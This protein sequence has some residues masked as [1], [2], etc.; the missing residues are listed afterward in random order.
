VPDLLRQALQALQQAQETAKETHN[1][2][3]L[4]RQ[5]TSQIRSSLDL[6]TI[7]QGAVTTIHELLQVESCHFI[8]YHPHAAASGWE[9]LQEARLPHVPSLGWHS[10]AYVES[11]AEVFLKQKLLRVNDV[12]ILDQP[13]LQTV[14]RNLGIKSQLVLPIRTHSGVVGALHC[15]NFSELYVWSDED[16]EWLQDILEQLAIAIQQAELTAEL[17]TNKVRFDAFFAGANAGLVIFDRQLRYVHIN[18]A[19]AETNGVPAADHIGKSIQEVL[20]QL[21]P[22]L[23]PMFQNILDTGKPIL[24]YE[25]VGETPKQPGVTRHWLASYYPLLDENGTIIGAGGVVI[26]IT[27]R[28]EADKAL[29]QSE[30]RLQAILDNCPRC[31]LSEGYSRAIH[32]GESSI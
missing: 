8:G 2:E 24:D 20:P 6:N 19:L 16:V 31:C 7:L 21:A 29:R 10:E 18:E 13:T 22:V 17:R 28:K 23:E 9:T 1:R 4:K 15:T 25:L 30:E 5:I 11:I 14:F 32:P 26:E 27:E 3:Q 12:E